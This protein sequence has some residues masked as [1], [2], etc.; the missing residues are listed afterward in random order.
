MSLTLHTIVCSTRPGRVG[1]PVA[2]WFHGIAGKHEAFDAKLVDLAD[3]NLP[4]Y[5]EHVESLA[6]GSAVKFGLMQ[7]WQTQL[8]RIVAPELFEFV[9]PSRYPSAPLLG[10]AT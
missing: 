7:T 2:Q 1:L 3:F 5:D 4:I 8:V 10:S 6:D 9:T